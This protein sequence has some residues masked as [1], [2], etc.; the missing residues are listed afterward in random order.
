MAIGLS[1]TATRRVGVDSASASR[2]GLHRLG[3][4]RAAERRYPLGE[5]EEDAHA[6]VEGA[7][8]QDDADRRDLGDDQP[9][10]DDD[11]RPGGEAVGQEAPQATSTSGVNM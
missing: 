11:Q 9:A 4:D 2:R 7:V 10:D 5:M 3:S 1:P 8:L 6:G